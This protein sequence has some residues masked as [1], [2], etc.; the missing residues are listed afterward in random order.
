MSSG[1]SQHSPTYKQH[2]GSIGLLD[3]IERVGNRL[4]DP[5]TLFFLAAI[6]VLISSE[7][8][9]QVGWRV[10]VPQ[11]IELQQNLGL[12]AGSAATATIPTHE[13]VKSL[14]TNEGVRWI[15]Q[16]VVKNFTGFAPLG[17]VLVGMIGIGIAERAGMIGT[18]L[19][20]IVT[21]TPQSL[22]TPAIVFVG[23]MSSVAMDAGFIV[24]PPLAAAV[25]AQKGRAPVA[26]LAAVFAGVAAGFSAN[27]LITSLDALLQGFT[28]MAAEILDPTYH[29]DIRCNYYFMVASTI[30]LT[31]AGWW[32][33]HRFVEPRFGP[34]QIEEQVTA[35]RQADGVPVESEQRLTAAE[36]RGLV[37]AALGLLVTAGGVLAMILIPGAPLYGEEMPDPVNRPSWKV[38]IWVEVIVPILFVIFLVPGIC[39]GVAARTIKSDREAAKMMGDTMASMGPYIVLAFFAAQFIAWF[40]ESNLGRVLAYEGIAFLQSLALPRW[41]LVVSI[42]FVAAALNMLIG[43]ASA[44]WAMISTVF[45]PV[46]MG[47]GISPELTQAAYRVGDSVTNIIS[48]LN[49]YVVIVVVYMRKYQPYAG[50]GS[51]ISIM[52]PYTVVFT[53][54]WTVML[55]VWMLLNV[56]LGPGGGTLFLSP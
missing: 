27:L 11:Q 49:P 9:A 26:G 43:S 23:V 14:L 2:R 6:L 1:A 36:R 39:Y 20:G 21:I 52:L 4:P 8:A 29:V 34:R 53:I 35:W 51:L 10:A 44:K 55:L 37:A 33:T 56:P 7:I 12:V 22:L 25:F 24:L 18:L 16:H 15:W 50:I 54:M 19:K 38:S 47:V 31:L 46:F 5:V 32:T 40:Q 42:V 13:G 41:M 3:W 30:M 17:V 48:P 45:V 28:Q